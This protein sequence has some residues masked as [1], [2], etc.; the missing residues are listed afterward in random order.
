MNEFEN[1]IVVYDKNIK[2]Y[3]D[4][5]KDIVSIKR[6]K[7]NNKFI[8][9][10]SNGKVYDYNISNVRWLSGPEALDSSSWLIYGNG[11]RLNNVKEILRFGNGNSDDW[12]K[13]VFQNGGIS[14]YPLKRLKF[15]KN[16]KDETDVKNF[17]DYLKK[18][19]GIL[20][21]VSDD[22]KN[23]FQNEL[24][25]LNVSEESVLSKFISN[26]PIKQCEIDGELIFP[27]Q[28]NAAQIKA[29]KNALKFDISC[30]QGPP[31][32]G[33]TQTIINIIANLLIRDMKVAVVAGN[34]EATRNV[35]EKIEREG[36]KGIDAYLGNKENIK[37]FFSQNQ[38]LPEFG[39]IRNS[40]PYSESLKTLSEKAIKI[41]ESRIR[42]AELKHLINEYS[43]EKEVNDENYRLK[44]HNVPKSLLNFQKHSD[45]IL[46][47]AAYLEI[48][49]QKKRIGL[50]R[51]AKLIFK[52]GLIKLKPVL[53]NLNE[54]IDFLQ[55]RYYSVKLEELKKEADRI[56][57]YLKTNDS[58]T[59]IDL[60]RERS[61]DIFRI[62]MREYY[63]GFSDYSVNDRDR[64]HR[65]EK[66]NRR[67]PVIYST[68]HALHYC[69][70]DYLYDY[71][72]MDESSQ[73]DLISAVIAMSCAKRI[74]FVGDQKQLPH[75]VKN[76]NLTPLEDL[77]SHYSLPEHL[78]YAKYS[79]LRSVSEQYKE[80]MP[81]VLLNE[82]YR[83]DPQI[84]EFC[85]KRF[86][87]GELVVQT[88]HK[89][90]G[91]IE[92]VTTESHSE[93]DRVNEAQA[94]AIL[95]DILP[96]IKGRDTGVVAP[97]RKQ[98]E[99]IGTMLADSCISVDTVHKFQGKERDVMILSTVAN[100]VHFYED[101]AKIDF[102]NNENLI[103]V[104]VSRA[105]N[106]LYVLA[107]KEIARQEGT[108]L[109][110]LHRYVSYYCGLE[111][112]WKSSV[113]SVFDLM[114]EDYSPMLEEMKKRLLKVSDYQSEN[115]VATLVDDI[116]NSGVFGSISFKHNY[117]LRKIIRSENL[118]SAE[119]RIFV[120]NPNTHCDFLIFNKLDKRIKLVI[121]V[122]GKQHNEQIQKSRDERKDRLLK[123]Y[124]I[125][126]LRLRTTETDCEEKI[127]SALKSAN[128]QY[129][130]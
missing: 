31:G 62:K 17:T 87:N 32:T 74:V 34:N 15:V 33:K 2:N 47:L 60:Y 115:I 56:E 70:G 100:K 107:N 83:C 55:N 77:F 73:V 16:R 6:D 24:K 96:E 124:N 64:L 120:E 125:S 53:Q 14:S 129:Y 29:V 105:K 97:Y 30:I 4:K 101:E 12:I 51:K 110:D 61:M 46:K 19:A 95:K 98:V 44:E 102:L 1:C 128:T 57:Q 68:T 85:N 9:K 52:Y 11:A 69:S 118:E 3:V 23:F 8:I 108:L 45:K 25:N 41:Y 7:E 54:S 82:H 26:E 75:V 18:I 50:F 88:T 27:L 112:V 42:S 10:F 43:I 76:Q 58:N 72:I 109:C 35:H 111:K 103:N 104:A 71:V 116:C 123:R 130:S 92:W 20:N 80:N 40:G 94:K 81:N 90:G 67:Y 84:I 28:T 99:L 93:N 79:I 89:E 66:I 119:D 37:Q 113:Y 121:E 39:E 38:I 21:D 49:S 13:I 106:K 65:F 63:S 117:P 114:Y 48:L 5:S 78:N 126:V 59:I 22:D 122:D 86:Y 127:K 91:G 36:I